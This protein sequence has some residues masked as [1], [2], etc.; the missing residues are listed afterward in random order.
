[1]LKAIR[2]IDYVILLCDDVSGMK[3]FYHEVMGFPIDED[4]SNWVKMRV[5]SVFLT[6][7]PRGCSY[8]GPAG[9]S[10]AASVQ[11]AFRVAPNEVELCYEELVQQGAEIIEKPTDQDWGH[12]TLFFRDPENNIL[13]IYADI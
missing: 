2:M 9:S 4:T 7:R 3:Q 12:K 11:L 5:G 1:M 6:L 10:E 8:D 13:E